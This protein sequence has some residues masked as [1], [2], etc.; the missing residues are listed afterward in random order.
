MC[1]S[2][3]FNVIYLFLDFSL[4]VSL[5]PYLSIYLSVCPEFGVSEASEEEHGQEI[6]FP[7]GHVCQLPTVGD[8]GV[9]C[10]SLGT[11]S[12]QRMSSDR[13]LTMRP[14]LTLAAGPAGSFAGVHRHP[15]VSLF[16]HR[17]F[18]K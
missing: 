4:S 10:S 3:S 16:N 7:K 12:I 1:S 13:A 6:N 11:F 17:E 14:S 5:F 2:F 8:L 9:P 18:M 15:P